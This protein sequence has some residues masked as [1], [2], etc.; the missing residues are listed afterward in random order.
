MLVGK[1]HKNSL[2]GKT[3]KLFIAIP[4]FNRL[5]QTRE[6]VESLERS[7]F[8]DFEIV[9]CDDGST[10]GTGEYLAEHHPDVKV[11]RGDGQLWWTGG[12]NRCLE[13]ILPL[14]ADEDL[15]LTLN[16]DVVVGPEFLDRMIEAHHARPR[17][18]IGSMVVFKDDPGRIETA[19]S[20]HNWTTA[21]KGY[22]NRFGE[23]VT[24]RH[25]GLTSVPKL[26]GK[27]VLIPVTVFRNIGVYDRHAFPHYAADEDF[28]MRA[29]NAGYEVLLNFDGRVLSDYKATGIGTRHTR[30][31][32]GE[33]FRSLF[34]RRSPNNLIIKWRLTFRH[35]PRLLIPQHLLLDLARTAGGFLKRYIQYHLQH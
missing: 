4:V 24:D 5:E 22:A 3:M 8:R 21:K 34:S 23:P 11:L 29:A 7:A 25:H 17:A 20:V 12:I 1:F 33:F 31:V 13:Y 35:C 19:E 28:S 18:L 9:I 14:A 26:C 32:L 2:P 27:G 15:V 16:N 10:D 6:C 30:P